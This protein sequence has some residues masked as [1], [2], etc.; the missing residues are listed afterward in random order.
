MP[1]PQQ[2]LLDRLTK[3]YSRITR[4]RED[5]TLRESPPQMF[6]YFEPD[7]VFCLAQMNSLGNPY[8]DSFNSIKA[9]LVQAC[10]NFSI[11][12]DF[13]TYTRELAEIE[14]RLLNFADSVSGTLVGEAG[15]EAEE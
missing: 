9:Y 12:N 2:Y 7:F 15:A 14:A 3:L 6:D 4:H 13:K 8:I 10:S 11:S 5:V 1:I